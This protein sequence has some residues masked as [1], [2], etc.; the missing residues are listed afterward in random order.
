MDKDNLF[1]DSKTD[2]RCS[3]LMER[4]RCAHCF[5]GEGAPLIYFTKN[6]TVAPSQLGHTEISDR[7]PHAIDITE[8]K[9]F[10]RT[11]ER[12]DQGKEIGFAQ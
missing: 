1:P 8:I 3:R 2:R 5:T 4:L 6:E 12:N 10:I 7:K 9:K 11:V